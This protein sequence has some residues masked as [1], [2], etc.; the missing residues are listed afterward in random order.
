MSTTCEV[1]CQNN[2][3]SACKGLGITLQI[4]TTSS[5]LKISLKSCVFYHLVDGS[6][7]FETR[8]STSNPWWGEWNRV[9]LGGGSHLSFQI[10]IFSPF[11]TLHCNPSNKTPIAYKI[12][13]QAYDGL[14]PNEASKNSPCGKYLSFIT[15]ATRESG[16]LSNRHPCF[17][18]R[19]RL[20]SS[21]SRKPIPH[22]FFEAPSLVQLIQATFLAS[23]DRP[24]QN[25]L[26]KELRFEHSFLGS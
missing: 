13:L 17:A 3:S 1:P 21:K 18:S 19:A 11:P 7:R 8:V 2:E 23:I 24:H 4:C 15:R 22:F 9:E 10:L 26:I 20:K 12:F 14:Y 25:R 16:F 6:M 5:R